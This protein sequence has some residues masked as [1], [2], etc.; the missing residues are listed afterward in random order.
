MHQFD[1]VVEND[2]IT[3]LYQ[4]KL[5]ILSLNIDMNN[6]HE[7]INYFEKGWLYIHF[8]DFLFVIEMN[9]LHMDIMRLM[10]LCN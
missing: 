7:Q 8:H 4:F 5:M 3:T 2:I 10:K 9:R 6:L 1:V